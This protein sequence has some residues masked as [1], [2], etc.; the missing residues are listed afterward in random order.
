MPE[1]WRQGSEFL[2]RGRPKFPRM[3][4]ERRISQW[5]AHCC[6]AR[7]TLCHFR[8]VA[9][10]PVARRTCD[11][12]LILSRAAGSAAVNLQKIFRPLGK[13]EII[14]DTPRACVKGL[15]YPDDQIRGYEGLMG[16]AHFPALTAWSRAFYHLQQT[17]KDNESIW[18]VEED[19]AGHP[20][21]FR[22]LVNLCH[23]DAPDLAAIQFRAPD[24]NPEWYWWGH[25]PDP[26][27]FARPRSSFNP[28]CRLSSR[29][30]REV[31]AVRA[32]RRRFTFHEILFASVAYR[33]GMQILDWETSSEFSSLLGIFRYRPKVSWPLLGISHPVKAPFLHALI[34]RSSSGLVSTLI[35]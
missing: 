4:K 7:K 22:A 11:R 15:W 5:L 17:L 34:S 12:F 10:Q 27:W 14:V 19:V 8:E 20:D 30:V 23:R 24:R 29:L 33:Q 25:M 21:A 32:G 13:T 6:A 26:D 16:C 9:R 3:E 1:A 28:L 18:F 2:E 35:A 31:L